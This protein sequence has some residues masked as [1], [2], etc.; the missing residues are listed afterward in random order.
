MWNVQL[1]TNRNII[2]NRIHRNHLYAI[3]LL[4]PWCVKANC[5]YWK[6]DVSCVR[7]SYILIFDYLCIRWLRTDLSPTSGVVVIVTDIPT[8]FV[9]D[10]MELK[11]AE[12]RGN[13]KDWRR[14]R[15]S[16]QKVSIH[17]HY[18][19]NIIC[20]QPYHYLITKYIVQTVVCERKVYVLLYL[21]DWTRMDMLWLACK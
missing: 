6:W 10:K 3:K 11:N 9:V 13:N 16:K 8:G 7:S 4:L 15:F 20:M 18:V 2:G 14:T 21:S 1:C 19:R 12:R 5:L 17:L